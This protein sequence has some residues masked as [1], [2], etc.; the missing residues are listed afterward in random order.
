MLGIEETIKLIEKYGIGFV[1]VAVIFVGVV[2]V[3]VV[4]TKFVLSWI[5]NSRGRDA[6]SVQIETQRL[7]VQLKMIEAQSKQ[8]DAVLAQAGSTAELAV[9]S[10]KGLSALGEI[11]QATT[12]DIPNILSENE[13][14]N[15]ERSKE[16]IREI[17]VHFPK[18]SI[19]KILTLIQKESG[20]TSY[21]EI[22]DKLDEIK[23]F[24]LKITKIEDENQEKKK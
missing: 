17:E 23:V 2:A 15:I 20:E 6:N 8:S 16:V 21:Q 3:I 13:E 18:G 12:K 11:H 19:E 10:A 7:D 24:L 22:M 1:A 4:I 5:A 9:S 14:R